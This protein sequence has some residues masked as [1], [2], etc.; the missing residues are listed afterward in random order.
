[1]HVVYTA[2]AAHD[3]TSR[4]VTA[5]LY[6]SSDTVSIM[7]GADTYMSGDPVPLDVGPNVI[8]YRRVT[9]TDDTPLAAPTP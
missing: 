2:S 6:N 8:T 3:V 5:T 7:K 9:T 4:T 1:M